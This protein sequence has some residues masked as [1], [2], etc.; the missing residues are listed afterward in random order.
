[1]LTHKYDIKLNVNL[2]VFVDKLLPNNIIL[3]I[4]LKDN[5]VSKLFWNIAIFVPPLKNG[6]FNKTSLTTCDI[7]L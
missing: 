5:I 4:I 1:M 2:G 3:Q 6:L 7:G